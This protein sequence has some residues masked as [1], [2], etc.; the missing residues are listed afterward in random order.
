LKNKKKFLENVK[1]RDQ[2]KKKRFLHRLEKVLGARSPVD[3]P[4]SPVMLG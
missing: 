3:L 4:G 2:N 1:K